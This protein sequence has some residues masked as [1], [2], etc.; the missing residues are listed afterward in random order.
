MHAFVCAVCGVEGAMSECL[1]FKI[2]A[3]DCTGKQYAPKDNMDN[4]KDVT[5]YMFCVCKRKSLDN[6]VG[7]VRVGNSTT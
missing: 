7:R 1:P 2:G 6:K 5:H 4:K 3:Q